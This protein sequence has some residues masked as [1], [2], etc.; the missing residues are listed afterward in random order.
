MTEVIDV[1]EIPNICHATRK[2]RCDAI[3][4]FT[5]LP[6]LASLIDFISIHHTPDMEH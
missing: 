4:E 6:S 5:V 2:W 3:D 1:C